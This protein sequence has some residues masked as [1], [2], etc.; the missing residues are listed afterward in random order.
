MRTVCSRQHCP[1][2]HC[3]RRLER[4]AWAWCGER[5]RE[6]GGERCC[7]PPLRPE[8]SAHHRSCDRARLP[9]ASAQNCQLAKTKMGVEFQFGPSYQY[10]WRD[11]E[12]PRVY[13]HYQLAITFEYLYVATI[14]SS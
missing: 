5:E 11:S 6:R 14:A 10:I 1:W 9:G 7:A 12:I 2:E 13:E 3:G 8:H 4:P